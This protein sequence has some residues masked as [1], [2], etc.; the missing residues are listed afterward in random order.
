MPRGT[1]CGKEMGN[2]QLSH[3]VIFFVFYEDLKSH[4]VNWK[5]VSSATNGQRHD[6]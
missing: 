2:G 1:L 5:V 6:T 4:L 3:L